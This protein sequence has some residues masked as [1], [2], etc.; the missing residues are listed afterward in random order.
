MKNMM[1]LRD[2]ISSTNNLKTI[3]KLQSAYKSQQN[4]LDKLTT[5]TILA[6]Q[7]RI[8]DISTILPKQLMHPDVWRT[9]VEASG[10]NIRE[11]SNEPQ[12]IDNLDK[13]IGDYITK[14]CP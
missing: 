13:K 12:R 7:P 14:D 10:P 5:K 3:E 9:Y 11:S 6:K 1:K 2:R 8:R 4:K